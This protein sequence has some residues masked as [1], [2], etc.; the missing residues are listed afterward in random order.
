MPDSEEPRVTK[1]QPAVLRTASPKVGARGSTGPSLDRGVRV[2]LADD[3][4]LILDLIE[5][6]IRPA[7][8]V[9]GTAT[10]G[11]SLLEAIDQLQPDMVITDVNMPIMNGLEAGKAVKQRWPEIK[12]V[13]L[14]VDPD[15]TLAAKA[16]SEGAE[17]YL[18]KY[19]RASEL[20]RALRIVRDGGVYLTHLVAGGDMDLLLRQP[21]R[22]PGP[23]LS[24]RELEVVAL[25]VRGL[26]MKQVARRLNITPRTV[27]FHKYNAMSALG[28]QGNADLLKYAMQTG[29]LGQSDAASP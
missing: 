26:P 28:L 13:Y 11:R 18:L 3:H 1:L 10:N 25:L 19:C 23:R 21:D 12:L 22:K 20:L 16:F 14:T 8:K 6:M 2:L 24:G 7:F 4:C 27:A 29:L 5:E 15:P 9:V 17:G